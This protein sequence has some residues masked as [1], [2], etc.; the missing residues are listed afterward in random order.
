MRKEEKRMIIILIIVATLLI[1]LMLN[2]SKNKKN[3]EEEENGKTIE[4]LEQGEY[5]KQEEDGT[6]VNTSE[7]LKETKENMGFTITNINYIKRGEETI[8][9]ARVTNNTGKAQEEFFGKIILLDKQGNEMAQI[10]VMIT[11]TQNGEAIDIEATIT[12]GYTNAYD[13]KLVK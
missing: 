4:N 12:E 10:P 13:F 11:E 5:T 1:T 3:K 6:I 8:L 2:V 9:T 7:K